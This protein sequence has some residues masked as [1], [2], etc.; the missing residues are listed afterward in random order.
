MF[1]HLIILTALCFSCS[2]W[3]NQPIPP[4]ELREVSDGIYV[5]F[6]PDAHRFVDANITII[7]NEK[8]VVIVDANDNLQNA[9]NL[10]SEILALTEKPVTHIINTHWHSDHTL[11]NDIYQEGFPGKQIIIGHETLP[12]LIVSKTRPQLHEKIT[13]W[14]K[15]IAKAEAQ[16]AS[17]EAKPGMTNKV[18][19]YKQQLEEFKSL[20]LHQ[21]D[22]T[23]KHEYVIPNISRTIKL[24]NFGKAHTEG[25]TLVYLPDDKIL[26]SGDLFD[27]LPYAGHGFPKSWLNTL[28]QVEKLSFTHVI[29]GHGELQQ[30]KKQLLQIIDLLQNSI[31]QAEAAV[32]QGLTEKE[33][34]DSVNLAPYQKTLAQKDEL[35]GRAFQHFIPEFFQQAYR[36]AS[37]KR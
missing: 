9:R 28:K 20:K 2:V 5:A 36:E 24:L 21:P 4:F 34:L 32:N 37:A 3:S 22:I 25:D 18:K 35:A 26:I 13:Q 29:P 6:K 14:E 19:L 11:A 10:V 7:E 12:Q 27:E 16:I 1:K 15:G 31:Q 30:G 17:G 8:S 33:F 23:F